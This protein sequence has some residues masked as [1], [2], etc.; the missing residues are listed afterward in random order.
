MQEYRWKRCHVTYHPSGCWWDL[1]RKEKRRKLRRQRN[2]SL[3]QLRKKRSI[4]SE[5]PSSP[6]TCYTEPHTPKQFKQ[7]GLDHEHAIKVAHKLQAQ[8]VQYAH[9]LVTT[10]RATENIDTSHSQLCG[11]GDSRLF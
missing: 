9:K 1:K 10:R 5:E 7:L 2:L 8:S 6:S 3:H 11:R 4:G